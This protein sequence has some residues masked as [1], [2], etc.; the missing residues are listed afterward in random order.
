MSDQPPPPPPHGTNP[1]RSGPNLPPG[2]YD[3]F[4]IPPHSSG[5]GF[6]YLPSLKPNVNSFAAGFATALVLVVLFQ[7]MA[8]AFRVWYSNFQGMGNMGMLL[9]VIAVGVGAWAIGRTQNEG[10]SSSGNRGDSGHS[11][12]YNPGDN[13]HSG[14]PYSGTGPPPHS[15]AP[16]PDGPPPP[17]PPHSSPPPPRSGPQPNTAGTGKPNSSWQERPE[18]HS[19]ERSREHRQE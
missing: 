7:S 6:L 8:P 11:W 15:R 2:K 18:E 4:I 14:G 13:G 5:A 17:P 1:R 19:E 10:N 3:I 12:S 9:L 16:D